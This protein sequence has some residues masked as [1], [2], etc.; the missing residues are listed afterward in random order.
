VEFSK[1]DLAQLDV[2]A[3]A[4]LTPEQL[5][6]LPVKLLADLKLAH[7]RLDRNPRNSS[8]PPSSMAPWDRGG[9]QVEESGALDEQAAG[10]GD[11]A[12]EAPAGEAPGSDE[13][14]EAPPPEQSGS[15]HLRGRRR[16]ATSA[17]P[18]TGRAWPW[19]HAAS[20]H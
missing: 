4:A 3:L 12:A 1:H 5:H 7:K 18:A 6:A 11:G 10:E 14:C 13:G 8:R 19:A 15:R 2:A 17:R 9:D 20:A 16:A